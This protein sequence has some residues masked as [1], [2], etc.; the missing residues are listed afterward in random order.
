MGN[1]DS[2][3]EN[4]GVTRSRASGLWGRGTQGAFLFKD[5]R[6]LRVKA[7]ELSTPLYHTPAL[8]R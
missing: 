2:F 8:G 1:A 5:G 3:I 6:G 7:P 4:L